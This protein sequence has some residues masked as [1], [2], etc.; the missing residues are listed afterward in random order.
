MSSSPSYRI[1]TE[2]LEKQ[3]VQ[4]EAVKELLKQQHIE[5]PLMGLRKFRHT[6]RCV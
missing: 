5:T 2:K 3:G 4:V 6:I 1:L